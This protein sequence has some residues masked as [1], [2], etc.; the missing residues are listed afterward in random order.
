MDK[1]TAGSF[2]IAAV[3]ISSVIGFFL[4]PSIFESGTTS[5]ESYLLAFQ[6]RTPETTER[7]AFIV[8]SSNT[9]Y[10]TDITKNLTGNPNFDT[11]PIPEWNTIKIN[12]SPFFYW[13]HYDGKNDTH[14]E[15]YGNCINITTT[16]ANEHGL[17]IL[18]FS[19]DTLKIENMGFTLACWVKWSGPLGSCAYIGLNWTDNLDS[20]SRW[21]WEGIRTN[22]TV[23]DWI[24]VI[25]HSQCPGFATVPAGGVKITFGWNQ[26]QPGSGYLKADTIQFNFTETVDNISELPPQTNTDGFP[27][28][29]IQAYWALKNHSYDDKHI[30]LMINAGDTDVRVWT[31]LV[32]DYAYTAPFIDVV[33]NDVNKSRFMRELNASESNSWAR[34]IKPQD[35]L[36]IYMVDHGSILADISRNAT[37]HF[38]ADGSFVKETEIDGLLNTISCSQVILMVDTCFSGNFMFPTLN[39]RDNILIIASSAPNKLSWYW[40]SA[41]M[42]HYAGSFFFH[43]FW[44][45][46][47]TTGNTLNDAF[48]QGANHIP[49]N[50]QQPNSIIQGPMG[51]GATYIDN[52]GIFSNWTL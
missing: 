37:Y 7:W 10:E 19:D 18:K 15:P 51:F 4:I 26:T 14:S 5:Q 36:L 50:H 8:A 45:T 23:G 22:N 28:Q 2:I 46:L 24:K 32:N 48:N 52:L 16:E 38:D 47:N 35:E 25:I 17:W 42:N 1:K 30:F 20:P 21:L 49:F 34:N 33:G 11:D 39:R 6:F 40:I 3:A 27:A 31:P 43:P 44:D 12:G 41:T 13:D 29:A 9:F